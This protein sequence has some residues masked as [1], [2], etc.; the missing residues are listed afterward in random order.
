MYYSHIR[1]YATRLGLFYVY[2]FSFNQERTRAFFNVGSLK[3]LKYLQLLYETR[4]NHSIRFSN[5]G[6]M[7]VD[8]ILCALLSDHQY[9]REC[10]S[11]LVVVVLLKLGI[12]NSKLVLS[13][14]KCTYFSPNTIRKNHGL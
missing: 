7:A 13:Y 12:S 11:F 2:Y 3:N 10:R 14:L 9:F 6:S 1:T 8:I 5:T 4:Q